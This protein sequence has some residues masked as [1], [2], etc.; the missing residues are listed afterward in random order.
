MASLMVVEKIRGALDDRLDCLA[1]RL[2]EALDR[3]G[4]AAVRYP[5]STLYAITL[6]MA[7]QPSR[8]TWYKTKDHFPSLFSR[9]KVGDWAPF[10][11]GFESESDLWVIV[12]KSVSLETVI[13]GEEEGICFASRTSFGRL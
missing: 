3:N 11:C 9:M 4:D 8:L 13:D 10:E 7:A 6:A 12:Q 1:K 5:C 2:V